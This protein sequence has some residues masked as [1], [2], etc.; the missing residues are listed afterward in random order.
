[1]CQSV[2]QSCKIHWRKEVSSPHLRTDDDISVFEALTVFDCTSLHTS[3]DGNSSTYGKC[4]DST[5]NIREC[6]YDSG[7]FDCI[8]ALSHIQRTTRISKLFQSTMI[9]KWVWWTVDHSGLGFTHVSIRCIMNRNLDL[10]NFGVLLQ[11]F[12]TWLQKWYLYLDPWSQPVELLKKI[13][14]IKLEILLL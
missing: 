2:L 11:F 1:M 5:W 9:I 6:I 3:H 4:D 8:K 12:A 14:A 13:K 7:N 10:L